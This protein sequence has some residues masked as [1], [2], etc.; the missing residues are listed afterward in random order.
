MAKFSRLICLLLISVLILAFPGSYK[1]D[2]ASLDAASSEDSLSAPRPMAGETLQLVQTR[3]EQGDAVAQMEL[4]VRL[5]DG[6]GVTRN[7]AEAIA[8]F[9]Q[10]ADAGSADAQNKLGVIYRN[11]DGVEQSY[12]EA[13]K[14]FLKASSQKNVHG[15]YNLANLYLFG[16]IPKKAEKGL[17]LMQDAADLGFVKAMQLAGSILKESKNPQTAARGFAYLRQAAEKN[18]SLAQ[19]IL[20]RAYLQGKG[21][22]RDPAMAESWLKK[23]A[24]LGNASASALLAGLVGQGLATAIPAVLPAA[25]QTK[26]ANTADSAGSAALN[27]Q[28]YAKD[29]EEVFNDPGALY[30]YFADQAAP[31]ISRSSVQNGLIAPVAERREVLGDFDL[32][33]LQEPCNR[34]AW[35]MKGVPWQS[36]AGSSDQAA[37]K[38]ENTGPIPTAASFSFSLSAQHR[39][40]AFCQNAI[41]FIYGGFSDVDEQKFRQLWTPFFDH[42]F[43]GTEEYFSALMPLLVDYLNLTSALSGQT[44]QVRDLLTGVALNGDLADEN[45]QKLMLQSLG[46]SLVEQKNAQEKLGGVIKMIQNLGDPPN[47]LQ[48]K[49]TARRRH[50]SFMKKPGMAGIICADWQGWAPRQLLNKDGAPI[51]GYDMRYLL[52]IR[53]G[54][55][56]PYWVNEADPLRKTLRTVVPRVYLDCNRFDHLNIREQVANSAG[57]KDQMVGSHFGIQVKLLPRTMLAEFRKNV[58]SDFE[59]THAKVSNSMEKI[60]ADQLDAEEFEGTGEKPGFMAAAGH[61]LIY[62]VDLGHPEAL[63]QVILGLPYPPAGKDW[64]ENARLQEKNAM[65]WLGRLRLS[66]V[67]AVPDE[68]ADLIMQS[69]E[70][71]ARK[72]EE[73]KAQIFDEQQK[74]KAAQEQASADAADNQ[75]RQKWLQESLENSKAV[76]DNYRQ[77]IQA[78][79]GEMAGLKP[80]DSRL[81]ALD[82]QIAGYEDSIEAE[83]YY[84]STLATGKAEVFHSSFSDRSF[85]VLIEKCEQEI[86]RM[87]K[88]N[89]AI[90][91]YPVLYTSLNPGMSQQEKMA[92]FDEIGKAV[93]STEQS[94]VIPLWRDLKGKVQNNKVNEA[95]QLASAARIASM[96]AYAAMGVARGAEGVLTVASL[97]QP[98]VGQ[99]MIGFGVAQGGLV[100]GSPRKAFE[101]G[102]RGWSD[103]VDVGW[104]ATEGY[105]EIEKTVD[106]NGNTIQRYKGL[107]GALS[108]GG[109]TL[110]TNLIMNLIGKSLQKNKV[111]ATPKG[112]AANP[113]PELPIVRADRTKSAKAKVEDALPTLTERYDTE[114]HSLE[115][116]LPRN[117]E[118]GIDRGHPDY[119]KQAAA[120]ETRKKEIESR[121][122]I[123]KQ[124]QVF[125]EKR[126]EITSSMEK[127]MANLQRGADG[128]IVE[129]PEYLE[130]KKQW[131]DEL[132]RLKQESA[133]LNEPRWASVEAS[134]RKA[135]MDPDKALSGGK[136][137][138]IQSDIDVTPQ[139]LDELNKFV[140]LLKKDKKNHIIE[141]SDRYVLTNSDMTVWKPDSWFGIITRSSLGSEEKQRLLNWGKA[142]HD[143][144][145]FQEIARSA[146]QRGSD[147]FGSLGGLVHT[148]AGQMVDPYGATMDNA[149]KFIDALQTPRGTDLHTMGK[150]LAKAMEIN[151]NL[152]L[153]KG[154]ETSLY[155]QA[156]QLRQH[157]TPE[158]A[159]IVQFGDSPEMK[160]QK[161]EEFVQKARSEMSTLLV[162][163]KEASRGFQHVQATKMRD[164][165]H[166]Y[167]KA[168]ASNDA[169]AK[170][171]I[172]LEMTR[173]RLRRTMLQNGNQMGEMVLGTRDPAIMRD[174]IALTDPMSATPVPGSKAAAATTA[175]REGDA[176]SG[177]C[178]SLKRQLTGPAGDFSWILDEVEDGPKS[179]EPLNERMKNV[180]Q[181]L[182][183][184]SKEIQDKK[185][186]DPN[187]SAAEKQYW[188]TL[189]DI[190]REGAASPISGLSKLRMLTGFPPE[191]ALFEIDQTLAP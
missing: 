168:T 153:S 190:T 27:Q 189:C 149:K 173:L 182:G 73:K 86:A 136:P 140:G 123:E 165:R 20:G 117:Q 34:Q 102:I 81:A 5:R 22:P 7:I 145:A 56:K 66:L 98:G 147:K 77:K 171:R 169:A 121:Y 144:T 161:M 85:A 111:L 107:K 2:A 137:E 105:Y 69:P 67:N 95:A 160:K 55:G 46:Q 184:T 82:R 79:K 28:D 54:K 150:S 162:K 12:T 40:I 87:E 133:K 42:P 120:I 89:T 4:A 25:V 32:K 74:A 84:S 180:A 114:I 3:A 127:K 167:L 181:R 24:A 170:E 163:S 21:L 126:H 178:G 68:D 62:I 94:G 1:A 188:Q 142:A 112:T 143:P 57:G 8:M 45:G 90:R 51:P 176:L 35:S 177:L 92:M 148:T 152:G 174:A 183:K 100:E 47:P 106:A 186:G 61:R 14:W 72:V 44:S 113:V 101:N 129:T 179:P 16:R 83:S 146:F 130:H 19:L 93:S 154:T 134:L 166:E 116:G 50:K 151:S 158:E 70:L 88:N 65:D 13:E 96:K 76:I 49:C 103:V 155:Q 33:N 110:A 128:K 43:Q 138:T 80:G 118:G 139:S 6:E 39:K 58:L 9:T 48:D 23:S 26:S 52:Q 31:A 132:G 124:R 29:D 125:E 64:T 119:V 38:S 41:R 78:I 60:G 156:L 185:L 10:L 99:V 108:K 187:L 164:L 11:G 37:A 30:E 172:A 63:I 17:D 115:A 97:F 71:D 191:Q 59:K 109:E 36:T 91:D 15:T 135:G 157:K 104:A 18:D 175:D 122:E 75:A 141:L 131:L 53:N 159:G